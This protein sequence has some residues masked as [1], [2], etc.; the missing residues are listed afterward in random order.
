[1][2]NC[3]QNVDLNTVGG[4]ESSYALN[5]WHHGVTFNSFVFSD[6]NYYGRSVKAS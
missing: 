1:M 5:R 3:V 6:Q 2:K 4:Q